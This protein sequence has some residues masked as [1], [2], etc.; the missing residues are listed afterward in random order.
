[1]N[2]FVAR[3]SY[4]LTS[5]DLQQAFEEFGMVDSAKVVIDHE[6]GRS[7]GFGFVEMPDS[8]Q[9]NAAIQA[10]NESELDGRQ[11]IVKEA[12]PR[13]ERR[14]SGGGEQRRGGRKNYGG[15]GG[16]GYGGDRY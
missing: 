12:L 15:G 1:M 4:N 8:D 3:L 11:I 9:A 7:K 10:L 13:E 2:I 16:G 6:T 14:P 5:E